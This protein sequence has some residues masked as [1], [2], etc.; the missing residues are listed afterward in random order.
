M[1]ADLEN[2]VWA[3]QTVLSCDDPAKLSLILRI[4]HD[5]GSEWRVF[6]FGG[7]GYVPPPK[8]DN[9]LYHDGLRVVVGK[10]GPEPLVLLFEKIDGV[11]IN[12]DCCE[13][14]DE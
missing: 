9:D 2:E 3:V 7:E 13:G 1:F 8:G 4:H 11:V 12:S 14:G 10:A 6:D 5:G